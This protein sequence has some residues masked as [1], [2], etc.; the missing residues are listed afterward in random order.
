MGRTP[1]TCPAAE[2]EA[3]ALQADG[4]KVIWSVPPTLAST[5]IIFLPPPT[6]TPTAPRVIE[7]SDTLPI[8]YPNRPSTS[9]NEHLVKAVYTTSAENYK[10]KRLKRVPSAFVGISGTLKQ[11]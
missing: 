8:S 7:T 9:Q 6:P 11:L 1:A 4:G 10:S 2:D 5:G 3:G